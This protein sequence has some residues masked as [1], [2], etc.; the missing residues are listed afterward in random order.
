M[1]IPTPQASRDITNLSKKTIFLLH[2]CALEEPAGPNESAGHSSSGSA[3]S[4]T[5]KNQLAARKGYDKLRQVQRI[6]ANMQTELEGDK[7]WRYHRQ[8]SPGLQEYIEALSFAHYLDHETLITFN[9]VQ[10]TLADPQGNPVWFN[11]YISRTPSAR[12]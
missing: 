8:V 5:T 6:Y 3:S 11:V 12:I 10:Q 1:C 9:E 2:R 7:F 4:T